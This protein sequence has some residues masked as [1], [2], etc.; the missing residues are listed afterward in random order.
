[1]RVIIRSDEV[2]LAQTYDDDGGMMALILFST[3][4]EVGGITVDVVVGRHVLPD[5]FGGTD[6]LINVESVW[7]SD[8]ADD[9]MIGSSG[10]DE[11]R[12]MFGADILHWWC[13]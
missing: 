1:M 3:F 8:F 7:G 9:Q 2:V 10:D 4:S 11:L 6:T 12:G 5:S 13:W